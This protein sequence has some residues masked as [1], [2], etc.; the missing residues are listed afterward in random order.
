MGD[1]AGRALLFQL[2]DC[3]HL[4]IVPSLGERCAEASVLIRADA[5]AGISYCKLGSYRR[6]VGAEGDGMVER[7]RSAEFG[8]QSATGK[9]H[10]KQHYQQPYINELATIAAHHNTRSDA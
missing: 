8:E 6:Y 7:P 1:Q 10:G 5:K 3:N 2:P 9:L 4:R